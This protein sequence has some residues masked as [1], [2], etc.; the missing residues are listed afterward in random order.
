MKGPTVYSISAFVRTALLVTMTVGVLAFAAPAVA[1]AAVHT[2]GSASAGHLTAPLPNAKPTPKT[3]PRG[4]SA[5]PGT[6]ET[7]PGV[8]TGLLLLLGTGLLVAGSVI[9]R[10]ARKPRP[11][12]P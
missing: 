4:G 7:G 11:A 5:P 10:A 12:R 3:A 2:G 9:T 6:A 8:P 1:S